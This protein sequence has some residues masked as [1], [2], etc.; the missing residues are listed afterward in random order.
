MNLRQLYNRAC[1]VMQWSIG[2]SRGSIEKII[3]EKK[4]DLTFKWL[5][6][7]TNAQSIADPFVFKDPQ[8]NINLLY[9]DF[10]MVDGDKYGK[11]ILAK[12]NKDLTTS[13]QVEL[14]DAKSHSSY[15]FVFVENNTTYVIPETSFQKKVSAYE[16]DFENK[17]LV[18]ERVL[19]K[20]RALLDPTIC[21]YNG[22]YWLFATESDP[23]FDHG[24]LHI[25]YGDSLFG[26]YL[27]HQNNPVKNSLNGSRPAGN[28]IVVDGVL[29]RPTQNCVHY[30]GES[31]S[32]NQILKLSETEFVEEFYFKIT[33]DITSEFKD[34]VHTINVID[35]I[36]V[37]DGIKMLFKPFTKW[38]LFL[39]KK[40]RKN[41]A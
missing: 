1:C 23:Q 22:K 21:K 6:V 19:I 15:P 13:S 20:G 11:I 5:P 10:S 17:S 36:I 29:Y 2:F 24:A 38:K 32:I 40:W 26:P 31:I 37:V 3:R 39:K 35:D 25:F 8:G 33:P 30:Y 4:A 16:Y 27:A 14:L 28:L 34:G 12:L 41:I 9:E 18:R 7:G